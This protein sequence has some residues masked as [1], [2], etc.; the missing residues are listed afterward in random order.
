MNYKNLEQL[1]KEGNLLLYKYCL[2]QFFRRKYIYSNEKDILDQKLIK[3]EK[4]PYTRFNYQARCIF[5][6]ENKRYKITSRD[7]E[8]LYKL[9]NKIVKIDIK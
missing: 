7:Y 9:L 6:P 5:M 3:I 1:A 4:T 8:K 2:G